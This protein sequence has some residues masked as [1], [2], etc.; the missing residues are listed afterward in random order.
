MIDRTIRVAGKNDDLSDV[1]DDTKAARLAISTFRGQALK[2]IEKIPIRDAEALTS[3]SYLKKIFQERWSNPSSEQANEVGVFLPREVWTLIFR[4]LDKR[5]LRKVA[6]LVCKE[7]LDIIRFDWI[8]SGNLTISTPRSFRDID[9]ILQTYPMLKTL[10]FKIAETDTNDSIE[11]LK[12]L[13][14][15]SCPYLEM[16]TV[17]GNFTNALGFRTR[18]LQENYEYDFGFPVEVLELMF[19]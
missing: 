4:K 6:S 11:T 19:N 13:E 14:F 5:T 17:Q 15:D 7:W 16:V 10:K 12:G 18:Y 9:K 2:W 8:M 3:W 1:L